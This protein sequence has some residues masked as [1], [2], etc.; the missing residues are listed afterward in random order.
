MPLTPPRT[1]RAVAFDLDGLMFNTEDIYREVCAQ[2]TGRRGYPME[3]GV[4]D[5][6]MGHPAPQAFQILIDWYKLSDSIADLR[7]ETEEIFLGLLPQQLRPMQG[8][9]CLLAAIDAAGIPRGIAT[10]SR[11]VLVDAILSGYEMRQGMQFIFTAED[12]QRGKPNP[13][14]YLKAATAFQ[15]EPHEMLVLEDSGTGCRAAVAAGAYVIAVPS[16]HSRHHDFPGVAFQA[17]SLADP[18]IDTALGICRR[19]VA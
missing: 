10:S 3:Q 13:D 19:S 8:L 17:D 14:I 4:L 12:V 9:L 15:V 7:D 2:L 5:R 16:E 1:I 18:R 11:R 6:M